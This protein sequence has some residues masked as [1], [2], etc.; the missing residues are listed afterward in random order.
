MNEFNKLLQEYIKVFITKQEKELLP[1]KEYVR[2]V[3]YG[4]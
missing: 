3:N 2:R 4:Y 1:S